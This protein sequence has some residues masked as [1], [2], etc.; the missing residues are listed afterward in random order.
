MAIFLRSWT[1]PTTTLIPI[2]R[3]SREQNGI[4][5]VVGGLSGRLYVNVSTLPSP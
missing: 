5:D 3:K 1:H 4:V 2:L